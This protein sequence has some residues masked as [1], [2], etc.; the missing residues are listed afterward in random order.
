MRVQYL[1]YTAEA[2]AVRRGRP[3]AR[4][5]RAVWTRAGGPVAA[6]L[7]GRPRE[8]PALRRAIE[9]T[10]QPILERSHAP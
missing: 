6:L 2:D 10:F 7:V 4:D 8:M 9:E 3:V 1:G 5:L